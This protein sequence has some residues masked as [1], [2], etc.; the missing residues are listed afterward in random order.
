MVI[1][2]AETAVLLG[3]RAE[4]GLAG[5]IRPFP[6]TGS[7]YHED[8]IFLSMNLEKSKITTSVIL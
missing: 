4:A 3:V 5:R 2:M 8:A 6:A 1:F 7:H